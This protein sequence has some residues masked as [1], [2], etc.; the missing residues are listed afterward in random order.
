MVLTRN[1]KGEPVYKTTEEIK[2]EKKNK[3]IK[4]YHGKHV[5]WPPKKKGSKNKMVRVISRTHIPKER[6][7]QRRK[8]EGTIKDLDC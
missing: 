1:I 3:K 2:Q 6:I 5:S 8:N 7:N 4:K